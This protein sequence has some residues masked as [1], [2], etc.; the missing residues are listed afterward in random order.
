MGDDADEAG[1]RLAAE[2]LGPRLR[3]AGLPRPDLTVRGPG[4]AASFDAWTEALAA[5]LSDRAQ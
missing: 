1:S 2:S 3:H 5:V 4:F